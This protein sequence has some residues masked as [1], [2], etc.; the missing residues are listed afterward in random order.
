VCSTA[1]LLQTQASFVRATPEALRGSAIGVAA[2]GI[3]ASQ[4]L[5]VLVGG[6]LADAWSPSGAIA[7]C[8]A[9]GALLALGWAVRWR[10][11]ARGGWADRP[12]ADRSRLVSPHP[13]R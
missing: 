9:A 1:Y 7:A 12:V 3:V 4:G 8:G 10:R 2:S 6:L 11:A 5:A 13:S